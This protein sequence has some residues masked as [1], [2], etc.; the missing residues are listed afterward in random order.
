MKSY[1][2]FMKPAKYLIGLLVTHPNK[3]EWGPGKVLA[4][5]GSLVTVYFRD[6]PEVKAGDA[7]KRIDTQHMPLQ[8]A[9]LQ[10]DPWL[11]AIPPL[12][13][14][15]RDT[16]EPRLSPDAAV[17]RFLNRFPGG[18]ADLEYLH[19]ERN[20]KR[21]AHEEYVKR[22]GDGRGAAL[23]AAGSIDEVRSHLLHV[24]GRV[25]LLSHFEKFAFAHAIKDPAAVVSYS[26]ALFR[27]LAAPDR[28]EAA[29][30]ELIRAVTDLPA[31]E[32]RAGVA[33]WPVL[34]LF[35][36]LAQPSR[37]MFLK[38]EVTQTASDRLRFN[39]NYSAKINLLTYSRLLAL[40][41]VLMDM[42]RPH[43]ARDYIDVQSFIWVT[44]DKYESVTG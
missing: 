27:V 41:D 43:G 35:P 19:K 16:T 1:D 34:T 6:A 33:K 44:G 4:M 10:S 13:D 31:E 26:S 25:N 9:S 2:A 8:A 21:A 32:G 22:L 15:R 11:D 39:L 42:L 14:G 40:A 18:F 20:Y 12:I 7:I 29:F 3:P 37:F 30:G 24:E 17:A 28:D 5:S 36:F 23:L 38:P